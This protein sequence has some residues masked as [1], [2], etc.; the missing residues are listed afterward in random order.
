MPQICQIM[1]TSKCHII[2]KQCPISCDKYAYV[3]VF[4]FFSLRNFRSTYLKQSAG[5]IGKKY[6]KAVF[7]QYTDESFNERAEQK[8]RKKELGI[9]GPVIRAQIRDIIKVKGIKI[10]NKSTKSCYVTLLVSI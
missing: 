3:Q 5:R 7:A 10:W 8:Q 2:N 4:C 1:W 6:K 9:L